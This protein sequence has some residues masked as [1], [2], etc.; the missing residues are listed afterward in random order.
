VLGLS[1]SLK[2][3]AMKIWNVELSTVQRLVFATCNDARFYLFK[4]LVCCVDE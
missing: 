4:F 1:D 2:Y 3:K